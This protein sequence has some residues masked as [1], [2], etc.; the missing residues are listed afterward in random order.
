[1]ST[2]EVHLGLET[3]VTV[4]EARQMIYERAFRNSHATRI[5]CVHNSFFPFLPARSCPFNEIISCEYGSFVLFIL[6]ICD[7]WERQTG[8]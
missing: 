2:V 8:Y 5:I 3:R 6:L 4:M 1:M 7:A